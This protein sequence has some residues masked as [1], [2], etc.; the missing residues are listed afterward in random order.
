[1]TAYSLLFWSRQD[2]N[3]ALRTQGS[4]AGSLF[5]SKLKSGNKFSRSNRIES[6]PREHGPETEGI[7]GTT[8]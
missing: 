3:T 2:Q 5:K 4:G 7:Q 1:M 8:K 6:L